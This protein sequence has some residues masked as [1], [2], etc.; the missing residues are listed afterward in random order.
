MS[1]VILNPPPNLLTN[2]VYIPE[3]INKEEEQNLLNQIEQLEW[4]K[5][6]FF[7]KEAKRK[8]VHYGLDYSFDTRSVSPTIPAPPFL[9]ALI[10]KSAKL[11]NL[12]PED[13]PEI[14]ITYYP[15]EAGI[16]WHRDAPVFDKIIGISLLNFCEMRLR[17]R[18]NHKEQFRVGL[19]PRSAYILSGAVRWGWEHSIFPLKSPR[20]SVTLRSLRKK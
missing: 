3:F 11:V 4:Q 15:I 18:S 12:N 8:A 2:L 6:I 20:Y 17:K 14:L 9:T 19:E 5:V 13:L 7:N 1:K 10:E 16:G